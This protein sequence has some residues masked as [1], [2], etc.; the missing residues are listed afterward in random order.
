MTLADL[1]DLE[2]QLARDRGG[3]PAALAARDRALM[4][5]AAPP[6]E[7]GALLG[8]W[9]ESLRAAE[10]GRL[11]PGRT[12]ALAVRAVGSA[13][14]LLGLVLGWGAAAA[15]LRFNGREPVNV[16]DFLLVLVG[17]QIALFVLL[18]SSF[19]LPVSALG[20]PLFGLARGLIAAVYPRIAG[21]LHRGERAQ[22]WAALWHRLR[23]RRSL[24]HRLEPWILL[25]LTQGFG[26]AFNVGAILGCL[27]LIAFSDIAFSWST[28]LVQLDAH[29]FHA[30]VHALAAPF[31]WLW[32]DADPSLALVEA[33]RYSRLEGA[34][35]LSGA[36]RAA[37]PEL[38]GGWW[39]FLLSAVACYGLLPRALTLALSRLRAARILDK[40][41][42]DDAEVTR[43]ARRL[44]EPHVETR[45][46]S[47][48][49]PGRA[50]AVPLP[51]A[52][53]GAEQGAPAVLVLWRDIPA[54]PGLRESVARQ[55]RWAVR[56]VHAAGGRDY[57]EGRLRW[58]DALEGASCAAVVAEGWEPPDKAVL[59]LL[60]DLR[61]SLGARRPVL[62]LLAEV[63][64]EGLRAPSG[65]DLRI[66]QEGVARLEDP[67]VAV[68]PLAGAA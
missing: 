55:T 47:P 42:L 9:L 25:G 61:G 45:S 10:P 49:Q 17:V 35:V 53:W 12:V 31:G 67:Y 15:L 24:Y 21:R 63:R 60:R 13:L 30:L 34:Y 62:V 33:T 16:W 3:D 57:E 20:T 65:A 8:R 14:L 66:W 44:S 56:A 4:A 27:R 5:G 41:P 51:Q 23:S 6:A 39:P 68:E 28:T 48:E 1:I 32:Q 26:V 19:F 64:P 7:R 58:K 50:A 46:P 38:V 22:E 29:R 54:A 2:A 36:R 59:R 18:L 37:H 11:H 40:L 43:T 52:G